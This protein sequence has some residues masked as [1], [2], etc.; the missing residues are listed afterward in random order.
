MD[1]NWAGNIAFSTNHVL[2]PQDLE[3]LRHEIVRANHVK[4]I[5]SGHSFNRINDSNDTIISFL[6]FTRELS[7]NFEDG[8]V[9]VPAGITS[10]AIA[11]RLNQAGYALAN[12]GSLPHI[13]LVGATATAT[14]GSGIKN[15]NLS[16][17]IRKVEIVKANGELEI[18]DTPDKL[19]AFAV[20]LG[21]LGV[22]HHLHVAIE[23]T[24]EIAQ[25]VYL[26]LPLESVRNN[27]LG[28]LSCA[29]SVSLFTM[30]GE[31]V[32]DQVWIKSRVVGEPPTLGET[33]VG[34]VKAQEQVHPIRGVD[35]QGTTPQ[36]GTVGP[37]YSRLPHF[38]LDSMPSA[39]GE[40][41]SEYFVSIEDGPAAFAALFEI[42]AQIAPL[43]LVSEIRT[44]AADENWM[45][46]AYG[47]DSIAFHFTWMPKEIEVNHLL[48]LI[49][50]ALAPFAARPHWGKVFT[51]DNFNFAQLYPHFQDFVAL[52]RSYD[53]QGKFLNDLLKVWGLE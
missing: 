15:Q 35:P 32:V 16:G 52:R 42:R 22:I 34:A 36:L 46:T 37:W 49:E 3:Q 10:G 5:G 47:R 13:S 25:E 4:V 6:G 20:S 50:R 45:S 26:D 9:S 23:P 33:L 21:A 17:R 24:Y 44:V 29:Y 14:H 1:R 38:M 51:A 8:T 39:G 19:P 12:M 30:W 2:V 31:E 27:L 28:I 41:Q 53:P 18:I 48:P 11:L 43:L 7:F 40:L